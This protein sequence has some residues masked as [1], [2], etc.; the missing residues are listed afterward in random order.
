MKN[1]YYLVI[2]ML[3]ACL[4]ALAGEQTGATDERQMPSFSANRSIQLTAIVKAINHETREVTLE[5][6]EGNQVSFVASEEARNLDQVVVGDKVSVDIFEEVSIALVEGDGQDAAAGQ[7]SAV[8]R[9][10]KGEAPAGMV[11]DTL[12]VTATVEEINLEANTF[13][14]K[15]PQ[16]NVTQF[17]ARNPENLKLAKLGDLVV[18]TTTSAIALSLVES[19]AE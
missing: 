16:G 5:G 1:K 6:P 18:I 11:V 12:I 19:E 3:V 2:I 14:L 13:K 8:A 10:E 9:A 17:K 15:G 7:I 4:S